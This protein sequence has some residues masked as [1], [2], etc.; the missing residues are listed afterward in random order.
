LDRHSNE[1]CRENAVEIAQIFRPWL[2]G[3][4]STRLGNEKILERYRDPVFRARVEES[5]VLS[6]STK[7]PAGRELQTGNALGR[8]GM[9]F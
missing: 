5:G 6:Q 8:Q 9:D 2:T 1:D 3:Q 7:A 4:E